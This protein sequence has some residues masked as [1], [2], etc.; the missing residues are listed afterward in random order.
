[1]SGAV[2]TI[3]VTPVYALV[4]GPGG[5]VFSLYSLYKVIFTDIPLH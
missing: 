2:E 4:T 5:Y 3:V 1:M